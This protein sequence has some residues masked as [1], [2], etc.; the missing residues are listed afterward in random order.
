MFC[1]ITWHPAGDPGS[2]KPT[3][4][5]MIAQAMLNYS[6]ME[7][8]LH[9]TCCGMSREEITAHLNRAKDLGIRNLLA[10]RGGKM[11][12]INTLYVDW[13]LLTMCTRS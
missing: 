6:G 4:S 8:M 3:S 9:I 1:D 2:D 5:S 12:V 13:N 10:L 7:T 11:S